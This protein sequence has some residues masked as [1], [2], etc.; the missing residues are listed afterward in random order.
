MFLNGGLHFV[1]TNIPPLKA[2]QM[3]E[4]ERERKGDRE[5]KVKSGGR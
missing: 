2:I 1:F 3:R 4:R 5:R